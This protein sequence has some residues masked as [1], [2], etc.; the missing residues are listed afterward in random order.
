MTRIIF[1][2]FG[3]G[4]CFTKQNRDRFFK[5]CKD[6]KVNSIL[7]TRAN[8]V[9]IDICIEYAK[10]YPNQ[11]D[12]WL[13]SGAFTAWQQGREYHVKEYYEFIMRS[14]PKLTAFRRVFV[15]SLDKIPGTINQTVTQDD[16]KQAIDTTI[17]NTHWLI[18]KG[19]KVVPIHHQGEPDW[20][21]K[22]YLKL[23]DYVG[24]SPANDSLQKDRIQYVRSLWKLFK[25]DSNIIH[26]AHNF[27]NIAETQLQNFPFYSA[28]STSW[29]T[30]E[31]YGNHVEIG[32]KRGNKK[33]NKKISSFKGR[34][35]PVSIG[36][37]NIKKFKVLEEDLKKLWDYRQI[38]WRE[39]QGIKL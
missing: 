35:N 28:D 22:E 31:I 38:T 25:N 13:D 27:G 32:I 12:F 6:V 17:S 3:S 15:I 16:I 26:P 33:T 36:I 19:L 4:K 9:E 29:K 2:A 23:A 18:E 24:I 8:P 1:A 39:P 30:S 7:A 37:E 34:E 20:V 10:Q 11:V 14:L 21:M 5:L